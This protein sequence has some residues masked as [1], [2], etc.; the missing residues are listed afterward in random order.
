VV[1]VGGTSLAKSTSASRGWVEGAWSGAGSGC[2]G[3]D[4]KPSWQKDTGCGKRTVADVSAVADPNTGAAV[5]DG[6]GSG[7]WVI[8]GGVADRGRHLGGH[9]PRPGQRVAGVREPDGVLRRDLGLE[10]ELRRE[11]PVHRRRGLRRAD[12]Q[13]HAQRDRARRRVDR[14]WWNH[15][16]AASSAAS[17]D[18]LRAFDLLVG[19][20]SH[21]ELRS[22]RH[23]GVRAGQLLLRHRVGRSVRR[24]SRVDLR[25]LAV[26]GR[27]HHA[28]A[29]ASTSDGNLLARHLLD[30][31]GPHLGLQLV[32]VHHLRAGQLLLHHGVGLGVRERSGLDLRAELLIH[33]S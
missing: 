22:V 3:Y 16:A 33:T 2:S 8:V 20:R 10:R 29:A 21:L 18:E 11:L 19:R 27:R 17:A 24:R 26:L 7:G 13:W 23:Q 4:G 9:R 32:R 6:Y 12:G 5:Y 28:S 31:P 14:R 30:G 15:A 1:A 25:L